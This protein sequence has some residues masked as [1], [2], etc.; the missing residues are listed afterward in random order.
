[1]FIREKKGIKTVLKPNL[2]VSL[3][4]FHCGSEISDNIAYFYQPSYP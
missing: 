1:M 4:A 2:L 3:Q